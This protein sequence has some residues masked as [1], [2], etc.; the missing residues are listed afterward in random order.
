MRWPRLDS[1]KQLASGAYE[2]CPVED[3]QNDQQNDEYDEVNEKPALMMP[4]LIGVS[5]GE[6]EPHG[7]LR[8]D[9]TRFVLEIPAQARPVKQSESQAQN[10]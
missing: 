8:R 10:G 4:P 6:L 2:T 5:T 7:S 1:G 3:E 9:A